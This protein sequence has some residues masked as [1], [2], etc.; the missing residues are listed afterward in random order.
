MHGLHL[1][2]LSDAVSFGVAP[3]I[4][5]YQV[6]LRGLAFFPLAEAAAWLVAGLYL[7]CALWRLAAY[8]TRAIQGS[9][10]QSRAIFI[11]LPSPAA[12]AAVCSMVFVLPACMPDERLLFFGYMAY[13]TLAA[14]LMVS[15]VPY[16]HGRIFLEKNGVWG[17]LCL[18]VLL[19]VSLFYMGIWALVLWAHIY[20]FAVPL[21][22][23]AIRIDRRYELLD[24]LRYLVGR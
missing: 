13:G 24:R 4:V 12:A 9:G 1:D 6:G 8:N 7:G 15:S 18:S 20:I 17:P 14:L 21:V 23:L 19:V 5:I 10:K 16:P 2:S 11:G 22:D 3:A